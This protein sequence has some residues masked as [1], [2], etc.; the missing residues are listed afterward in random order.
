[1]ERVLLLL[2]DIVVRS[3]TIQPM[4]IEVHITFTYVLESKPTCVPA[5]SSLLVCKS[6]GAQ[7]PKPNNMH[8]II[9][10]NTN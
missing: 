9:L 2:L 7:L 5:T 6:L 10:I 8:S 1:M 4:Q 3:A